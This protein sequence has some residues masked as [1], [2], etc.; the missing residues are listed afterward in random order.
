MDRA[1]DSPRITDIL[2]VTEI[3]QIRSFCLDAE[4]A[5]GYVPAFLTELLNGLF[6]RLGI[7][8]H[9]PANAYSASSARRIIIWYHALRI[10]FLITASATLFSL[11]LKATTAL[12]SISLHEPLSGSAAVLRIV[13]WVLAPIHF[14]ID[15]LGC[16]VHARLLSAQIT[17]TTTDFGSSTAPPALSVYWQFVGDALLSALQVSLSTIPTILYQFSFGASL[18]PTFLTGITVMIHTVT[19]L[20]E[21]ACLQPSLGFWIRNAAFQRLLTILLYF[22]H[23]LNSIMVIQFFVPRALLFVLLSIVIYL[24]PCIV[25]CLARQLVAEQGVS[26]SPTPHPTWTESLAVIRQSTLSRQR[27]QPIVYRF[28]N[29]T[30]SAIIAMLS[31]TLPL[32]L[33]LYRDGWIDQDAKTTSQLIVLG[34]YLYGLLICSLQFRALLCFLRGSLE[35]DKRIEPY[36]IFYP[37]VMLPLYKMRIM[38]PH[39]CYISLIVLLVSIH[40]SIVSTLYKEMCRIFRYRSHTSLR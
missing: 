25:N 14:V 8:L 7:D 34:A 13:Y 28:M 3:Q 39:I 31:I 9:V 11:Q 27:L 15:R 16:L 4:H 12:T 38:K 32:Y 5:I 21:S 36:S 33:V 37:L 6:T 1:S 18:F 20:R 40:Y 19:T 26:S 29:G 30:Y 2:S 23:R 10:S 24:L 17:A 35:W 22:V